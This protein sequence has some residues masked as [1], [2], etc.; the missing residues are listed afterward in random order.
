MKSGSPR[1]APT[2]RSG[3]AIIAGLA[4]GAAH[5]DNWIPLFNGKDL[6]GWTPKFA[7]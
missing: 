5:A 4:A 2:K 1:C 7:T 3:L 6:D